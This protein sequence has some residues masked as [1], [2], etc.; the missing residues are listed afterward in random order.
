MTNKTFRELIERRIKA[1]LANGSDV[2]FI[3]LTVG[4]SEEQ[5]EKIIEIIVNDA[6]FNDTEP[7]IING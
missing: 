6:F 3:A 1:L 4:I 7:E 5:T 2:S